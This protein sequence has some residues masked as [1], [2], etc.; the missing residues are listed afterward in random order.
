MRKRLQSGRPPGLVRC[1]ASAT[2]DVAGLGRQDDEGTT[3]NCVGGS[4]EPGRR[5]RRPDAESRISAMRPPT[6]ER[7]LLHIRMEIYRTL[8][9]RQVLGDGT[10]RPMSP[11][12]L[13][14]I[15]KDSAHRRQLEVGCPIGSGGSVG[16]AMPWLP[17]TTRA[18]RTWYESGVRTA[19]ILRCGDAGACAYLA[20][21][22]FKKTWMTAVRRIR[23][24]SPAAGPFQTG[25]AASP[26]MCCEIN[27]DHDAEAARSGTAERRSRPG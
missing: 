18:W 24:F 10:L 23:S 4:G 21:D 14:P 19:G 5:G 15:A 1:P 8:K 7:I 25:S 2:T 6:P 9:G 16:S 20:D 3:G 22:V 12:V 13:S 27:Y 11:W 17:A 26:P